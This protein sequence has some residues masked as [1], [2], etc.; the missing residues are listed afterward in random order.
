MS[1]H[2][3]KSL[4]H[5][6]A[7]GRTAG[8]LNVA[9]KTLCGLA[10]A[11]PSSLA[12]CLS[13]RSQHPNHT[14]F[15]PEH[16]NDRTFSPAQAVDSPGSPLAQVTLNPQVSPKYQFLKKA[17]PTS[18]SGLMPPLCIKIRHHRPVHQ[19]RQHNCKLT[20]V[21]I[22]LKKCLSTKPDMHPRRQWSMYIYTYFIWH[23][24]SVFH[25]LLYCWTGRRTIIQFF[26][27]CNFSFWMHG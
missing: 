12:W 9:H 19:S 14:D 3:L 4:W 7:L 17:S 23:Y 5:P 13:P 24:I 16:P 1:P 26:L 2:C 15:L 20:L 27:L 21:C 22:I 18:P 11:C 10:P 8:I 25:S 6:T